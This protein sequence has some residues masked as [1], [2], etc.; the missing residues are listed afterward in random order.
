VN[1]AVG[2]S[3]PV[4]ALGSRAAR[5]AAFA[6]VGQLVSQL[7]RLGSNLLLTHILEPDAFGLMAIVLAVTAGLQL[8]SDVGIWQAIVRSPRGDDP[9]FQNTAWT[10][11]AVRGVGLFAIGCAIAWPAAE[12]YGRDE[13]RWLLPVCALQALLLG[14]ESSKSAMA[15]R[16][17]LVQRMVTMEL[18]SQIVGL[19]IAVGVALATRSVIALAV[20]AVGSVLTRTL[21][22]HF[23]LEGPLNRPRW[24]KEAAREIFTFG[25]WIFVSTLL[26]FAGTRLDVFALGRLESMGTLG[27]YGLALLITQVPVQIGERVTGFVLMPAL[28]ERFREAPGELASDVRGAR[29]VLFPAAALLFLGAAMTAPAFFKLFYRDVYE[30]AGWMTQ[31]LVLVGW[32]AFV[33]D[34]SSRALVALGDSRSLAVANG[35]RLVATVVFTAIGFWQGSLIG[36]MLGNACAAFVGALVIGYALGK[37]GVPVL[38]LDAAATGAFVVTLALGCGAPLLLSP[39]VGISSAWLTLGSAAL[40]LG[41]LAVWVVQNGRAALAGRGR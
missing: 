27:L 17:L 16:K 3:I 10:L 19:L 26:Y 40:L 22:S 20:A 30:D 13:L 28:A 36:F 21:M 7:L 33:Q 14:V 24:E 38:G 15:N 6:S 18:S 25:G 4:A 29:R 11:N 8:I 35:A 39:L 32:C 23:Y 41:P 31:L 1:D 5:G 2:P 37:R 12:L 9:D 34:A